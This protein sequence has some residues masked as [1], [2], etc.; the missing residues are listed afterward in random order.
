MEIKRFIISSVPDYLLCLVISIG[1]TANVVQGFQVPSAM[2]TSFATMV[3]IASIVLVPF[4]VFSYSKRNALIGVAV[5]V[6]LAVVTLAVLTSNDLSILESDEPEN[7]GPLWYL[8]CVVCPL[9]VFLLSR[10]VSGTAVLFVGG[11]L[12]MAML[13]FLEYSF[14]LRGMIAFLVATGALFIY[15]RYWRNVMASHT[16]KVSIHA[17]VLA[18]IFVCVLSILGSAGVWYGI[19]KPLNPPSM[20]L[21]LITEYLSYEILDIVGVSKEV[22]IPD[23]TISNEPDN[24]KEKTDNEDAGD[25][26][27]DGSSGGN[28]SNADGQED[29]DGGSSANNSDKEYNPIFHLEEMPFPWWIIFII[30]AIILVLLILFFPIIRRRVWYKK[31]RGYCNEA[32]IVLMHNWFIK[33]FRWLGIVPPGSDTPYE[34]ADRIESHTQMLAAEESTWGKLTE[35]YVKLSYENRSIAD[36]DVEVYRSVYKEFFKNS[37][38]ILGGKYILKYFVI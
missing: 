18:G 23:D 30:L 34:Y 35:I 32:Q 2:Y 15:K 10:T 3:I 20:E 36:E 14:Y 27:D 33:K 31:V 17:V 38:K 13:A 37:R 22:E 26:Q 19:I 9:A 4:F 21:K 16:V 6:I 24:D 1:V 29:S 11:A 7:N 12:L 28:G 8:L 25:N 5:I